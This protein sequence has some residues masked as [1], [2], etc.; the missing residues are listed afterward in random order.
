M[1]KIFLLFHTL[2]HLKWQQIRYQI[3]YRL[4]K[5]KPFT[6]YAAPFD[7]DIHR[8]HFAVRPP[9]PPSCRGDNTFI[10]LHKEKDFGAE[11]DWNYD[12][13][14][15]LW[16]YNLQ[17]GN[18]WL[19]E[20][21]EPGESLRLVRELYDALSDGRLN[22]E[23]Y[24]ASLR[25]MNF[26]RYCALHP[27]PAPELLQQ[28]YTEFRFVWQRPEYHIL[29]NHLLENLFA[30]CMA[31]AFFREE[32]IL[33]EVTRQLREQLEEQILTDGAHFEL[34][35]MYHQIMLARVL[36]WID[37][38]RSYPD[39]NVE[40][41]KDIRG[42]ATKMVGW[43]VNISFGNG[44]IP[45]FNDAARG[46][47][48]STP[49][50]LEYA[51]QL[52]I[53]PASIRLSA[54]GYRSFQRKD[55]EI[56]IDAAPI[57][58]SYQPGH[59]HA[60]ALSFILYYKG[61]PLFVEQ[62]TSTYEQGV[63]RNLERSTEAHNTVVVGGKNQSEVWA[64]F[65][66]GRRARTVIL[67]E[68]ADF[69]K[70]RHDGYRKTGC[71]HVRSFEVSEGKLILRDEL[72]PEGRGIAYFHLHPSCAYRKLSDTLFLLEEAVKI[73]FEGSRSIQIESYQY[74]DR[75]YTYETGNRFA[76]EFESELET[77]VYF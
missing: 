43:L 77:S 58:A 65:R 12:G 41:E 37:W 48:C 26:I 38:Y 59:A 6:A 22:P 72:K 61:R 39:K 70:A 3:W 62:G 33:T 20:E 31:A 5:A 27:E 50:L 10:F 11:I 73:E 60:D 1:K 75:Y 2:R 23:P 54:S 45:L 30:L 69:L 74:A 14:G 46:I 25:L 34:S 16:N 24:P 19:Q 21:L 57:G 13:Y 67:E 52:D 7:G 56:K 44:E 68:S 47:A 64:G 42:K 40:A 49:F 32:K 29:G 53:Y 35:P 51:R 15:A 76:V 28:V 71:I 9:V 4:N 18:Y 66:V 17:Y 36:E 63:R 55:Y 8:L